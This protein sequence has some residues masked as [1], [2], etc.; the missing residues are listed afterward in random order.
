MT[1]VL[2]KIKFKS[3]IPICIEPSNHL[4]INDEVD[5]IIKKLVSLNNELKESELIIQNKNNLLKNINQKLINKL[6]KI[7]TKFHRSY[8]T[9]L[10]NISLQ[11]I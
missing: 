5:N 4:N 6:K 7:E 9:I 10:A 2:D 8:I 3:T 11:L 1:K